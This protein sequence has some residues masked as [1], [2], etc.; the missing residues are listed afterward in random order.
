MF[1]YQLLILTT[2][3][4]TV[5]ASVAFLALLKTIDDAK[6]P[7][8]T[9]EAKAFE[10]QITGWARKNQDK[11]REIQ[12]YLGCCGYNSRTDTSLATGEKCPRQMNDTSTP[13]CKDTLLDKIEDKSKIIG[14]V[15]VVVAFIELLTLLASCCV[16]W[17]KPTPQHRVAISDESYM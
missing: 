3:I 16:I 17:T 12:N 6:A 2:F 14:I 10:D 5:V 15:A 13:M 11:W 9:G 7:T 8:P 1:F 4:V